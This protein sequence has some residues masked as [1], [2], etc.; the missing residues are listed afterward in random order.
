MRSLSCPKFKRSLSGFTLIELLTTAAMT[1]ILVGSAFLGIMVLLQSQTKTEIQT[2]QEEVLNFSLDFMG[3]DIRTASQING[4]GGTLTTAAAAIAASNSVIAFSPPL[5]S[6]AGT[7]VLYLEI[8]MRF[9]GVCPAGTD[10]AGVSPPS[11][12]RVLYDVR[13]SNGVWKGPNV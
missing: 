2:R 8:P 6:N 10:F 12:E 3:D 4:S 9:S 13:T 1:I 11:V 5:S 7:Y